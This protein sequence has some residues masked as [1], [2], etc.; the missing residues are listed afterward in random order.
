MQEIAD[1][2][3]VSKSRIGIVIKNV[4]H[5]LD[6]YENILHIY[7]KR[8]ELNNLLKINDLEKIKERLSTIIKGE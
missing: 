4:E 7:A 6:N 5:K 8:E 3:H 2:Q 1:L